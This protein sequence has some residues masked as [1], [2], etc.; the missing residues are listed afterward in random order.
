MRISELSINVL[1][2]ISYPFAFWLGITERVDWWV[3]V[4]VVFLSC[5]LNATWKTK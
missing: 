3:I 1:N 4:M 2:F 5:E